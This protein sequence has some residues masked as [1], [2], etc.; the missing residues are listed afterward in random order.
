MLCPKCQNTFVG[1]ACD[2]NLYWIWG[3][4]WKNLY[5]A[6]RIGREMYSFRCYVLSKGHH[7]KEPRQKFFR[8]R[9]FCICQ[10][11]NFE[12]DIITAGDL[13]ELS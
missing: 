7:L 13:N 2:P 6:V 3:L 1:N 5:V 8:L 12:W 4:R 11:C 10:R 9:Y